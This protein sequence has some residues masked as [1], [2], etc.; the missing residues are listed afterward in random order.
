MARPLLLLAALAVLC[1]GVARAEVIEVPVSGLQG[2]YTSC[3]IT[4]CVSGR[5]AAFNLGFP[6][7]TVR[8]VMIRCSG[9]A[10]PGVA[11]LYGDFCE[12]GCD[13]WSA[14]L[15][16][17]I[18]PESTFGWTGLPDLPAVFT[19]ADTLNPFAGHGRWESVLDGTGTLG[20]SF[21]DIVLIPECGIDPVSSS[22]PV[23]TVDS[24]TLIFDVVRTNTPVLERTWGQIK[25]RYR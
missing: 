16:A 19:V 2:P 13:P 11:C 10:Q 7:D 9:T 23:V 15:I 14:G 1:V 3:L 22:S 20:L 8:S 4:T 21:N 18:D 25:T 17:V 5:T 6:L 24:V 12:P